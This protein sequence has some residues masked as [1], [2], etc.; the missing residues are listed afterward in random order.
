MTSDSGC[1]SVSSGLRP[2]WRPGKGRWRRRAGLNSNPAAAF[3]PATADGPRGGGRPNHGGGREGQRGAGGARPRITGKPSP[4]PLR[5]RPIRTRLPLHAVA[6]QQWRPRKVVILWGPRRGHLGPTASALGSVRSGAPGD[7]QPTDGADASGRRTRVL[8]EAAGC[9]GGMP[10][11]Q[12]LFASQEQEPAAEQKVKE[13]KR[14]LWVHLSANRF[15]RWTNVLKEEKM[16]GL[17][18]QHQLC[19]VGLRP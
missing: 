6:L 17:V 18:M 4:R 3:A 19:K 14:S 12:P 11:A 13:S 7:V 5:R 16:T 8:Q 10:V 2:R 15:L 1:G 9:V